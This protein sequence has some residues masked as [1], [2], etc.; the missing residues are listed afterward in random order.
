M[1]K[2]D[3]FEFQCKSLGVP[4]GF[5]RKIEKSLS[6]RK[7]KVFLIGGNVRSLILKKKIDSNPDLGK[8]IN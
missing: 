1:R 4:I 2:I 7:G 3:N 5:I 8:D 6:F